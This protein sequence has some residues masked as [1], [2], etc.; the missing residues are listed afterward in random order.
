MQESVLCGH[1]A[2]CPQSFGDILEDNA[3]GFQS[4]CPAPKK[5]ICAMGRIEKDHNRAVYPASLRKGGEHRQQCPGALG[6]LCS[7][8]R[9]TD[10][11][12]PG[13]R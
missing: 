3:R 4:L 1:T 7:S 9:C 10:S 11:P 12:Q 13:W 6:Q 8:Q 2:L 5:N